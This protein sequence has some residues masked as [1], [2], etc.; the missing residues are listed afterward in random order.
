VTQKLLNIHEQTQEQDCWCWAAV[1][2]SVSVY[3][4]KS[5]DPRLWWQCN[6]VGSQMQPQQTCDQCCPAGV[7]PNDDHTGDLGGA[8]SAVNHAN[9][10]GRGIVQ[11]SDI[12]GQIDLGQPVG[13]KITWDTGGD[14]YLLICGYDDSSYNLFILDPIKGYGEHGYA[15]L[16]T[17]PFKTFKSTNPS[18]YKDP[19]GARGHWADT[20]FTQ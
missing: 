18:Q 16:R 19:N 14:H 6:L 8:L 9:N 20:F 4:T 12:T 5:G 11:W 7:N 2:T 10:A 13:A 3:Y 15:V 1:A 17:V